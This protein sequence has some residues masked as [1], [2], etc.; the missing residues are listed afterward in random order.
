MYVICILISSIH[1]TVNTCICYC[2][3][4]ACVQSGL[5][6]IH[7]RNGILSS[8]GYEMVTYL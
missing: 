6:I 4:N 3:K 7:P 2:L 1:W 8:V 5:M